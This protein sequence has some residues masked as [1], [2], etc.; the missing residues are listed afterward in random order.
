MALVFLMLYAGLAVI[1][2]YRFI[3]LSPVQA[4]V[5]KTLSGIAAVGFLVLTIKEGMMFI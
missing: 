2:I 4:K 3:K 5:D 1:F